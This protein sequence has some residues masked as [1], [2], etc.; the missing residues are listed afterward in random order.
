[1]I[2]HKT[3]VSVTHA[4]KFHAYVI[5]RHFCI[6]YNAHLESARS[7]NWMMIREPAAA[8]NILRKQVAV[9]TST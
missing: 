6:L 5:T 9:T 2:S 4:N 7:R 1:M 8:L 3:P